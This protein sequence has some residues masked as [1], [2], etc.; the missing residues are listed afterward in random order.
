VADDNVIDLANWRAGSSKDF[1]RVA[2]DM[3]RAFR[4][5]LP[6]G[7]TI[8]DRQVAEIGRRLE[9]AAEIWCANRPESLKLDVPAQL[10]DGSGSISTTLSAAARAG[11]GNLLTVVMIE[12]V[13]AELEAL[14]GTE[15]RLSVERHLARTQ[16]ADFGFL[17][18]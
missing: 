14:C 7:Q 8:S 2:E 13:L 10:D 9:R 12:R 11:R 5:V 15:V 3:L 16:P 4:I 1:R 18:D 6:S 17:V